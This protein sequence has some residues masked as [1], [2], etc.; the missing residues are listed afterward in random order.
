[1]KKNLYNQEVITEYLLGSLPE[2]E[3]ERLDELS[4]TDDE[5][6]DILRVA[7]K[8]LIDAYVHGELSNRDLERFNSYYLSSPLRREKVKFAETFKLLSEEGSATH[9]EVSN[10]DNKKTSNKRKL[11][12]FF[13]NPNIFA[14]RY[15]VLQWSFIT[16]A[17]LLLV[18]GSWLALDNIRLRKQVTE[19]QFKVREEE[20]KK[21]IEEERSASLKKEQELAK[22][23]E[24]SK[25]LKEQANRPARPEQPLPKS[26]NKINIASFILA[27]TLRG[28]QSLPLFSIPPNTDLIAVQLELES[29]DYSTYRVVLQDVA[30]NRILWQSRRLKTVVKDGSK[31]LNVTLPSNLL[32]SQ[33][34][35]L[36]VSGYL[37]NG[38]SEI[39]SSYSFKVTKDQ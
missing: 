30:S 37:A 32:S 3:T 18:I 21:Q 14:L 33:T 17:C 16:I 7:E 23:R 10:T 15:P 35:L 25:S 31:V 20:L 34:Y 1:M 29:D 9:K 4:V 39:I 2:A 8:E 22:V 13:L 6:T 11:F 12:P 19:D 28:T 27:P 36:Q 24:E 38:S 26:S 5:F